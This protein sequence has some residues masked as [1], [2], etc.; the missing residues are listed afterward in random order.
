MLA[1]SFADCVFIAL[2]AWLFVCGASGWKALLMD[3]D[4]GWH[5]RTGEYILAHHA[6]PTQDLFSFSR[7]G[8]PW[9]AWE[10]LTDVLFS[11]LFRIGALKAIVLFAGVLIGIY[12]T[13]LEGWLGLPAKEAL[14][15]TFEQLPILRPGRQG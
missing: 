3:G 5:I 6:V 11:V 14:G 4:T 10:W 2:V 12:A 7:P 1:P 15:G 13:V 8:A 9:F